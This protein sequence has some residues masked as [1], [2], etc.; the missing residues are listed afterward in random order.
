MIDYIKNN[1]LWIGSVIVPIL[2]AIIGGI[3][4]LFMKSGINQKVGDINGNGNVIING[5]VTEHSKKL[6]NRIQ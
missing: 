1:Y 6:R 4:K 3:I 5:D 2:I